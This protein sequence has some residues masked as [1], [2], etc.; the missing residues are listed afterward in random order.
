MD[1]LSHFLTDFLNT[2]YNLEKF[3][4]W[5]GNQVLSYSFKK[6]CEVSL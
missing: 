5:D 3:V 2:T 1:F 4:K 6:P